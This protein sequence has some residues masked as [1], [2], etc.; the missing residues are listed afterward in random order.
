M[1]AVSVLEHFSDHGS[2]HQKMKKNTTSVRSYPNSAGDATRGLLA[3]DH[4]I[5]NH[6]Q[7]TWTTPELAP[8][9]LTTTPHQREDI[10]ALDRFS[11]HRCPTRRVFSGTGLELVTRQVT[12]RYLYHSATA[13]FPRRRA[14]VMYWGED[15]KGNP[16][17]DDQRA[18]KK[19]SSVTQTLSR[20]R[21]PF[22]EPVLH[23][24]FRPQAVRNEGDLT[25]KDRQKEGR[26]VKCERKNIVGDDDPTMWPARSSDLSLIENFWSMIAERLALHHTP[27]TTVDELWYRVEVTWSFVPLHAIQSLFDSMPRAANLEPFHSPPSSYHKAVYQTLQDELFHHSD[28]VSKFC[29]A[30]PP[31]L[32]Q[33]TNHIVLSSP[34]HAT[35]PGNIAIMIWEGGSLF[36]SY[37]PSDIRR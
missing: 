18:Q 17:N 32:V 19:A 28:F 36:T 6:G 21:T 10:S 35:S 33:A 16:L 8:P 2:I 22:E 14:Y 29:I 11:V 15:K 7:V 13:A 20:E 23:Q 31:F 27:V 34:R 3:T 37:M 1:K 12:V 26:V 25:G 4:V 24:H 9:L 5:L 30:T